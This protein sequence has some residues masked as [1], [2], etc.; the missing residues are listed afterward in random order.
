[1]YTVAGMVDTPLSSSRWRPLFRPAVEMLAAM[2]GGMAVLTGLAAVGLALGGSSLAQL[3]S[4]HP[5][6]WSALM[7]LAMTAP[8]V[9]WMRWRGHP[10]PRVIEMAAAM[11]GSSGALLAVHRAGLLDGESLF[12]T[13]HAVMVPAML[14]VMLWRRHAY[15]ETAPRLR[16]ADS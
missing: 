15:G 11:L 9:A 3:E 7:A 10:A 5:G 16:N 1:L 12:A 14:A 13:Q 4:G 6:L 8:T 2:F